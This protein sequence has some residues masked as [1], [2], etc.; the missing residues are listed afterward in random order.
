MLGKIYIVMAPLNSTDV[1]P[2]DFI[3]KILLNI[4]CTHHSMPLYD[5]FSKG[6]EKNTSW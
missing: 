2:V 4:Y 1:F 5:S 3:C 6:E